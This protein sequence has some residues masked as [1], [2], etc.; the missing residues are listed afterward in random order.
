MS[1]ETFVPTRTHEIASRTDN[2]L[3]ENFPVEDVVDLISDDE[4][5]IVN[6]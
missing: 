2:P 5:K 6:K 4:S 1:E 3:C